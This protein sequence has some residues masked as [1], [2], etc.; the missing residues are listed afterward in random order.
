[1]TEKVRLSLCLLTWNEIDGCRQDVPSLPRDLFDEVYAIDG[2]STDGTVEYLTERGITVHRQETPTYN[3]AYLSAFRHCTTH[4]VVLFHPKGSI[5]PAILANF[6][7]Y[8]ERGCDLVVASRIIEGAVNEEDSQLLRPRK[9]FVRAA[10]LTAAVLWN[11][12]GPM[13]WDVLHGCRGMRR[14]A[15]NLIDPL[16]RGV[17][18]DLEMVARAYRFNLK[19]GEFPVE[20]KPRLSGKTHFKA[21]PTGKALLRYLWQELGRTA[22][23][24]VKR[25][26]IKAP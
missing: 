10:A 19:R 1:M 14:D 3:G 23:G 15:F 5:D 4:A 2:G 7:S 11:R 13:V 16:P 24:A 22:N 9:W 12:E 21:W 8:F 26:E 6:R 18:I 17:S 25:A 20:E